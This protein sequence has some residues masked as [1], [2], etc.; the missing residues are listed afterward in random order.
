MLFGQGRRH[1][2]IGVYRQFDGDHP[3]EAAVTPASPGADMIRTQTPRP[4][5][6]DSLNNR[7]ALA[8]DPRRFPC[9]DP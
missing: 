4:M 3:N 8:K 1:G 7:R 6:V 2:E 9:A 5:Q